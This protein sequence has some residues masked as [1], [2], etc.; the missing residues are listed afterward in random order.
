MLNHRLPKVLFLLLAIIGLTLFWRSTE[1]SPRTPQK[2]ERLPATPRLNHGIALPQAV[3]S[4]EDKTTVTQALKTSDSPLN[5]FHQWSQRYL[6]AS[7]TERIA[8]EAEGRM[9]AE[10]RRPLFK[11]LIKEDPRKALEMAVPM[12]VRQKLP[13]PILMHLERRIN[14]RAAVT[15]YQG[16]PAPGEPLPAPGK[17]LTHRIAQ[18]PGQGAYNLHVYGRRAESILNVPNASINGVAIDREI[19]ANEEPLR[20]LE[21]GEIPNQSKPQVTI[22]PISG[23]TTANESQTALPVEEEQAEAVVETPEEVIYLCGGYHRPIL[24]TQLVYGEGSTGGPTKITGALPAAPT[25]ALG[26]LKVLFIPMTF[27]DTN[28][29]PATETT[30]YNVMRDVADYYL[31]SSFGRLTTLT[32][33][34]PPVKLPR[35][36]AWYVQR[37]TSNGGDIDGLGL[38]MADAR[39]QARRM[40]FDFNDYD[41]TV[42]RLSGGARP[43]GGWGGGNS[44][45][46]YGDSVGVT[47]HEIGHAF[48]LAHANFWDTAGTSAIG[49]GTNSEYGDSYDNMGSGAVP[50][51]HYNAAAKNQVKWM[52]DNYVQNITSS[53]LYRLHA[54][55]QPILDP[56]NRYALTIVKDAQRT[57]WG[58]LRQ[59]YNASLSRP[60]ADKGM[61]LGWKFPTGGGG[62]IQRIDTTPG[63]PYL[64]DDAAIALGSTFSDPEAGIFITTVGVSSSTPKYVDVVV[65]MGDFT[66]NQPPVLSLAASSNV[67][68]L[69]ATVTFSATASDPDGD[70]LAYQWQHWG[71][72]AVKIVSPNAASI[73]RTFTSAGSYVVSCTVSDMKG[74]TVTRET[75]ITVGTGGGKFLISGR[76][77]ADGVG[78]PNVLM[79]ANSSNPVVTDADGYYTIANLAANTYS[80][81]PLLYGYTFNELFNNSVTVGPNYNGANFEAIALPVVTI[82][83]VDDSALENSGVDKATLRI[84]RTGVLNQP[85]VVN[86]STAQGSATTNDYSLLPT[87]SSGS[88]FN[89]F[90]IPADSAAVEITVSALNDST[91]EGPETLILRL[92]AGGGYLIGA[93]GGSAQVTLEDDDTTLPKVSLMATTDST[94]EN[95]GTPGAFTIQRTG[96][97]TGALTVNYTISGTASA[98]ADYTAL[99]GFAILY[100]GM[101]STTIVAST[102]DDSLVESLET[103]KL[104]LAANAAYVL[105]PSASVASINI[106]DDDTATVSVSA[107]DASAREVDLSV[108][109]AA[110]DTGTFLI[111][112]SGD[113]SEALTV[114]YS[115]AGTTSGVPALNGV[116]FEALPGVVQI[117]AGSA[118]ASVSI[119]PH[120]DNLGETAEQVVLQLG[121]GPTNYLLGANSSATVTINDGASGNAPYL[122]LINTLSASE[123]ATSGKFRFSLKGTVAGN[124]TVKFAL[125]GTATSGSD[126][127][128]TLPTTPAG[129]SFDAATGSGSVVISGTGTNTVD[130]TITPVN[131]AALEDLESVICTLV[132]DA[133][134]QSFG[135]T[136]SATLSLRD[137][138]QPTVWVDAQVG[139]GAIRLTEGSTAN[140]VKFY[141]SRTGATTSALSVNFSLEGKATAAS[142]YAVTTSATLSFD[143]ATSTG[144]LTIPAGS[145]GADVPLTIIND[146]V[147]EGTE[148]ITLTPTDGAYSKTFSATIYLDDNETGTQKV[149]FDSIGGSGGEDLTSPTIAV[150][151]TAPATVPTTV[152]YMVDTGARSS[153]TASLSSTL[154]YWVR[155]VRNGTALTSYCST[156]GVT[157]NQV[158]STQTLSMSSTNYTAGILA[159]SSI[160]GTACT[161]T[162]DNVSITGLEAAGTVGSVSHA[163][164]GTSSPTSSSSEAAGVYTINAGGSD[165]SQSGTADICRYVFFPIANSIT[166][167]ITARISSISG[168]V[169][170]S[171][172][173]VMIRETSATTAKHLA[174]TAQKDGTA[175][176]V[177]RLTANGATASTTVLRPYWV[178]AQ[179]AGSLFSAFSS[180]DGSTWT[181]VGS[182]QTLPF[183]QDL[184]AGLAVSARSDGTLATATF[185][186]LTITG[187]ATPSLTGRTVGYVNAQGTDSLSEGVYTVSGSGAAIGNSEDECHFLAMPVS[188][189]FTITA[190]V[191]SQSGGAANSQA[192]VML[193]DVA[194]YRSRSFYCGMVANG[195][196]ESIARSSSVTTALG[197]TVDYTLPSGTLNFAVGEQTKT[198]PLA[199]TEDSIVE[200]DEVISLMLRNPNAA[201]LGTN[202]S[203]TYTI[204]DNDSLPALPFVGFAASTGSIVEAGGAALLSVSLSTPATTNV[205]VDYAVSG[206]TA[207]P[208][209][210]FT[211]N[212]GTLSF[213]PG[214]L[215]KTI[216]LTVLDDSTIEAAETVLVSLSNATGA[217]MGSQSLHTLSISDDDLPVVSIV[218]NDPNAAEAG[219]DPGQF[220]VTRTGPT[221]SA[222][223]VTLNRSGSAISGTD[224]AAI[225]S[226][227]SLV[228]P[229]GQSSATLSVTL[230]SNDS[231]NEGPETVIETIAPSGNYS[232]GTPGSATVT[233][234]DDDRST[235]SI[236]INDATAS[237]TGGNKGQFTISRTA[238]LNVALTVNLTIAGSATNTADYATLG[239]SLSFAASE[240]TKVIEVTPVDDAL[241]E[242]NEVLTLQIASGSYFI[243]GSDFGNVTIQDN[244]SP[245]TVY[246]TS[247]TAQGTLVASGNGLIVSA[248][249]TDDGAPQATTQL[250]TQVSGPGTATFGTPTQNTSTVT[251][252]ADGVY[253]LRITATDGQFTVND[254]VSVIVGNAITP[255]EWIAQ[256]LS[257]TT[258]QRGQSS[259]LG[260]TYI[261]TGMGAGYAATTTDAAHVMTR[262]VSGDGSIVARLTATGGPAAAPLAGLTIRDSLARS[263]NRAV[264]GYVPGIGLQFRTRTTVSTADSVTTQPGITLPVWIKLERNGSTVTASYASDV[265]GS[266]ATW[267]A[268]GTATT[269]NTTDSLTQIGLTATGNSSTAGVLGSGT[270]DHVTLTPTPNGPALITE[271]FGTTTPTPS[272]FS[273]NGGTYT[274]GGSGSMDGTGAFY[275]W[276]YSGDLMVTAKLASASSSALG[277]KS[278]IMIRE[279]MDN[280]AGYIHL[281]RIAQG[282]F[283]GYMW[284]SLAGGGGSGVPSFTNTVRWMR[285]VRQ[286][287]R[288]TAFHAADAGGNPGAWTQ[289][290]Q[291]QTVIMSTPVL[292][293]LAVDNSGGTA[294]V[295]NVCTFSNLSIVQL[296]KAPVIDIANFTSSSVHD[297]PLD[298]TVTD[299]NF[300]TPVNLT[301]RWSQLSGPFAVLFGNAALVDTTA[302]VSANGNYALRL[303]AD[304][305]SAVTFR[306]LLLNVELGKTSQAINF[307]A[308][309]DQLTTDS[310]NLSATGGSSGNPVTFVVTSGPAVIT[311]NV[312]TF[313]TS[314]PVTITASQAG[315]DTHLAA[316]EVSRTFTVNKAPASITLGGLTQNFDGS[317]R[318]VTVTTTPAN[319]AFDLTYAGSPT[320]PSNAGSYEVLVSIN[321]LIHQG[322]AAGRLDIAKL[323]QLITFEAIPDQ[324]TTNSVN[325]NATG[326]NSL[327][328]VTFAVASG[329][330]AITDNVL[331]FTTAGSVTVTASQAGSENYFAAPPVSRSFSVSKAQALLAFSQ[332]TQVADGT[333]RS[334][335]VSTTPPGLAVA[336][337]Y[338]GKATAPT[339]PGTYAVAGA[340]EDPIY[341]ASASASLTL[342]GLKGLDQ[343]ILSGST[344]PVEFNGTDYGSVSLGQGLNRRFTLLNPG[345]Q[346]I[347]LTGTALIAVEGDHAAD[348]VLGTIPDT[349]IPAA[350]AISFDLRFA[351]TQPGERTARVILPCAS[352]ANGPISFAVQGVGSPLAPRSQTLAF[353]PPTTV[354]LSQSPVQLSAT[355][356]SGLPVSLLVI[357]GPASLDQDGLLSLTGTGT[358]KVEARQAGNASFTAAPSLQR[359]I[360]VKTDPTGL[361]LVD[362][363]R[364]YNGQPQEAGVIGAGDADVVLTYKIGAA[365]GSSPPVNAGQYP[366]RAVAGSVT[367]TGT[368]IINPAPLYASVQNE[369]RLAGE[370]NP[371]LRVVL[372]GFIGTDSELTLIEKPINCST[373]ATKTSPVGSYPITSSGGLVGSNYQLVHRP[374]IMVVEGVVGSYEAL[375]RHPTSDLPNGHLTLTVPAASRTFTASL[376]LGQEIA[377]IAW[378]GGLTLS[379]ESRLATATVSKLVSG[380]AYE[381]SLSLAM[382][383]KLSCEVRRVG[384]P[385]AASDRGTLLLTLPAGQRAAQEG[386]YTAILEPAKPAAA[387]LPAGAGWAIGRI[388]SK[389]MLNLSGK[390]GDG[391]TFTTSMAADATEPPSYRFF[392]QPY[393]PTRRGSHLGGNLTLL[394]HPRLEGRF[395][396]AGSEMAWVKAGQLRDTSYRTDFGPV[397]STLRLDPWLAPTS[398]NRL[399]NRLE[400]TE[401]GLSEVAHSNTGSLSNAE[402]PTRVNFG[403]TNLVSVLAPLGNPR[404]WRITIATATGA[405]TGSFELLELTAVRKVNFSG[406]LR[407]TPTLEDDLIGA[408]HYTL[409]ALKTDSSQEQKTGALIFRRP[410]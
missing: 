137:D 8:L 133:A 150:S 186:Q 372:E 187:V 273:L 89:S 333:P 240:E 266:P 171:K 114:Y 22:C 134:Y 256:D 246:V 28:A 314:G 275:G 311:D 106:V 410:E 223:T 395:F 259:R 292:V 153:S 401:S 404:K 176:S 136:S 360:T 216:A 389:G 117:P 138:D 313:T 277:A 304:D 20:V 60:W 287:N 383:G 366:V 152:D 166:C 165:L 63:S 35:N 194:S 54:M 119:L 164:V 12:V 406:V 337:L 13:E 280:T 211:L 65:N 172:A 101:A 123:P 180:P 115:I 233:I 351:P 317:P 64:K 278:G 168:G 122:E 257:P 239:T 283:N 55:D 72:S 341:Q 363:I 98:D 86:L 67:V 249:V 9:L 142:D 40:G 151:L 364:T 169:A 196:A 42:L 262:Q 208:G 104:T 376:R 247:P 394:P 402:L 103:V 61:L 70:T 162:I 144:V 261:L 147:F 316:P 33:V 121:A 143:T 368:L 156:D 295:L 296:N 132:P 50:T 340:V 358:I 353:A 355:S 237:E 26:T 128:V 388:N 149:A 203:F 129:S 391:T 85:L 57:Y 94:I 207:T 95:S 318:Q 21:V 10:A 24:A 183:G 293:G 264:L 93:G 116:D 398:T 221:T 325:L 74:G 286:G 356:S 359:T 370:D 299:D 217:N 220:T 332:L 76:V 229:I 140:P 75:L 175:R 49:P 297:V 230:S 354:Y 400:L 241:T 321:D 25:P 16:M 111:T 379:P 258:Q 342:L 182:S 148:T 161:A 3:E 212:S 378:S 294:G 289:L 238:P 396:V 392:I 15:V 334:V 197:A 371:P 30:C 327:N 210:D 393:L 81:T 253:V 90:T 350:G 4:N 141:V 271:D 384:E 102:L 160:G 201:Q 234:A 228:I 331:T 155:V 31:K 53:G 319:L 268:L 307:A 225:A 291:P 252:S 408:G 375:L 301:T 36:E 47:A 374:G 1:P 361:T 202:S 158:G 184:L 174:M 100:E 373:T 48:G 32:T 130:L 227:L 338:A 243:G 83:A 399:T 2:S 255:A 231:T 200:P 131:D 27:Q 77:T 88:P 352:L 282:A 38:E 17:T 206:G 308:I 87:L 177:Y 248:L 92:A 11:Q 390:L 188:G 84:T 113:T 179:R 80:V 45:W 170:A 205:S 91:A 290:G 126:Y 139:S 336:T 303:Q 118:T 5:D 300:P 365:Y 7:A 260:E 335:A 324:L 380:I 99:K 41:C 250:W 263:S 320:A 68:P 23:L 44:V 124:V 213:A 328:P 367:K 120:W 244:D 349:Q 222:L 348:F 344:S 312:L 112:R 6:K 279:S 224:Y 407:Q 405:Y 269:I 125:T 274:I 369:R 236:V 29:V 357:S 346:P 46:I 97:T 305:T 345:P 272:T 146:T 218:A 209:A 192:G 43:T 343:P 329:P 199:I 173:G 377:P 34:T 73:T 157:F 232:V 276:Q 105:N 82:A 78:L 315:S 339:M 326:G 362:L 381:L 251:F 298:G 219:L 127:T 386:S 409:P 109:G 154:P 226:P 56:R 323:N 191:T 110:A 193:R 214:E 306:D 135:P 198:I 330:A 14:D 189:D 267:N 51:D 79:N 108:G 178:R 310:V 18:V 309:P 254:Q 190:R 62:N 52:P 242:G 302:S 96:S 39:E 265:S 69:N 281:G 403:P 385:V 59:N 245:P 185:D 167:T 235:V 397:T 387:T 284:R 37:D 163:T 159:A 347:A 66:G 107:T 204:E 270:F 215:V 71:D 285:L 195:A 288:V 58:E 19:A 181:Q 145:Q 322:S 382:T